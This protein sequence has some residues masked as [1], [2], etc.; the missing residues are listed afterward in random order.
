MVEIRHRTAA[1]TVV[2]HTCPWTASIDTGKGRPLDA[3]EY[4]ALAHEAGT[5]A[6]R[7]R[8]FADGVDRG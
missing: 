6:D 1:A 8:Y 2:C 3:D 4:A 7:H 5:L